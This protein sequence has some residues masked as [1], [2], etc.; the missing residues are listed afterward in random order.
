MHIIIIIGIIYYVDAGNWEETI[1]L[2]RKYM[3]TSYTLYSV[4]NRCVESMGEMP[5]RINR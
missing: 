3:T 5:C 1:Y 2:T 4:P